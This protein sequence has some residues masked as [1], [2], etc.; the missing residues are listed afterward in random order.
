MFKV[1]AVN[2]DGGG[3]TLAEA[4]TIEQAR[5][6]GIAACQNGDIDDSD[7]IQIWS[8]EDEH[9]AVEEFGCDEI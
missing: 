2:D 3:V 6:V 1:K 4:A 8:D 7:I 9:T 5:A